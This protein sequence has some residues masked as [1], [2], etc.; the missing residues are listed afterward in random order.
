M[1]RAFD[2]RMTG[3][4]DPDQRHVVVTERARSA[5]NV[6]AAIG[7]DKPTAPMRERSSVAAFRVKVSAMTCL[8]AICSVS[9]R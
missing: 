9:A 7:S 5:W 1:S 2:S 6:P 4:G 3:S 8:G